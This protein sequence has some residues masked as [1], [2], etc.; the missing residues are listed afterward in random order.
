MEN[1]NLT[2]VGKLTAEV[3]STVS[4]TQEQ[5]TIICSLLNKIFNCDV[6]IIN[7]IDK[8]I[9]GGFKISCA[10][11]YLDTSL[12]NDLRILKKQLL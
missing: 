10:D 2:K 11:W 7:K 12:K 4:L 8:N 3:T 1:N 5:K 9:L 6:N